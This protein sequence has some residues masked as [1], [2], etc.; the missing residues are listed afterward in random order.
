MLPPTII[1]I[2]IMSVIKQHIISGYKL[3]IK[4]AKQM[5]VGC[6]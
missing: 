5:Q 3:V 2:A 1:V 4:K 6:Y